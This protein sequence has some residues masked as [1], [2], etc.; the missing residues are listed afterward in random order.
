MAG[1]T[2]R[3]VGCRSEFEEG[4]PPTQRLVR[5]TRKPR[6]PLSQ[7]SAMVPP[8][9]LEPATYW[10]EVMSEA[11]IAAY[12]GR[13]SRA[14]TGSLVRAPSSWTVMAHLNWGEVG[15]GGPRFPSGSTA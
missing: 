8:A 6:S 1:T 7:A 3:Q 12:L 9:G 5:L 15:Y 10:F 14:G 4:R 11:L 2:Q 13:R